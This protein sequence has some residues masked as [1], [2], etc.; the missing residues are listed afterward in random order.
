[1]SQQGREITVADTEGAN[2]QDDVAGHIQ[3][4]RDDTDHVQSFIRL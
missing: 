1:M 2:D 3:P 4:P